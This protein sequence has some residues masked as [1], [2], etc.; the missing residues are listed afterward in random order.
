ML[1]STSILSRRRW[2][3]RRQREISTAMMAAQFF[4]PARRRSIWR[5][6][7]ASP[8]RAIPCAMPAMYHAAQD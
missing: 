5:V 4:L 8:T 2:R 1:A 3:P 7:R 6:R